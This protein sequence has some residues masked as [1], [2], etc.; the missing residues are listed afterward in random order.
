MPS[1][2]SMEEGGVAKASSQNKVL[3][4]ILLTDAT[5]AG[6]KHL[7]EVPSTLPAA[8][9][10][11]SI[12]SNKRSSNA[13]GVI[14]QNLSANIMTD[15]I[16][17]VRGINNIRI[18]NTDT[19][20]KLMTTI[21][22]KVLRLSVICDQVLLPLIHIELNNTKNQSTIGFSL[23]SKGRLAA[24]TSDNSVFGDALLQQAPMWCNLRPD[25]TSKLK[26][27][28]NQSSEELLD[29]DDIESVADI[30][31]KKL[32]FDKKGLASVKWRVEAVNG[33]PNFDMR[34]LKE[35]MERLK[36]GAGTV[37]LSLRM[38]V[39]VGE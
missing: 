22:K 24:L 2:R 31:Q 30:L 6:G 26:S 39:P 15:T 14:R 19:M 10:T 8:P 28:D 21:G 25:F 34:S 36:T 27:Y 18:E 11:T 9:S 5:T 29:D 23:S 33:I 35:E 38:L 12:A 13:D 32:L 37:K 17:V 16:F 20:H 4:E 1:A 3:T 7:F